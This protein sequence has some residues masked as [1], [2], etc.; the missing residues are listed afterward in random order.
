M[1]AIVLT[2]AVLVFGALLL[3]DTTA[4]I[5]LVWLCLTGHCGVPAT[6][7]AIGLGTL[8]LFS[9]LLAIPKFRRHRAKTTR[10]KPA[11]AKPRTPRRKGAK[12]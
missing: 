7:I 1:R 8:V 3:F 11:K 12:P 6:W 9:L 2:L 10:G 5:Q 4:L